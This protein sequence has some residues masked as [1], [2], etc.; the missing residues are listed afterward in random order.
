MKVDQTVYIHMGRWIIDVIAE[1]I[2]PELEYF[3]VTILGE[4][5]SFALSDIARDLFFPSLDNPLLHIIS[6]EGVNKNGKWVID[7]MKYENGTSVCVTETPVQ[8]H[9]YKVDPS[10]FDMYSDS[11]KEV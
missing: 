3:D 4:D 10:Y 8:G 5:A 7:V 11:D 1:E 2:Q 6:H 9:G